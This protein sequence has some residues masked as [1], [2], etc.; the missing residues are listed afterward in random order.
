MNNLLKKI[1]KSPL[2]FINSL[3]NKIMDK[4]LQ[5]AIIIGVIAL[6]IS[7]KVEVAVPIIGSVTIGTLVLSFLGIIGL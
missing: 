3:Y 4:P 5:W 7:W 1:L 2:T 6:L